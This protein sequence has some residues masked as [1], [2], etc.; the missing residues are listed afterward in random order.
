MATTF[1]CR[2]SSSRFLAVYSASLGVQWVE[3]ELSLRE[4]PVKGSMSV[5]SFAGACTLEGCGFRDV[6]LGVARFVV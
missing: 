4:A 5:A 1:T 6:L 2:E 3:L